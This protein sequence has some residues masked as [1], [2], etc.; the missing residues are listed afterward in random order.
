V[1]AT[2]ASIVAAAT[3]LIFAVIG[4]T[5]TERSGVINLSLE[6]SLMLAALAGFAAGFQTGEWWVGFVAAALVGGAVAG[7]VAWASIELRV[8]QVAVGFVLALLCIELS[9]FLGVSFVGQPGAAV[10]HWEIPL[11]ADIPWLGAVFFSHDVVV[12][13]GLALIVVSTWYMFRTGPGLVLR[14]IGERPE[15]AHARAV[16]VNRLRYRYALIG[17][18]LV[19]IGGAAFSL[20]VKLGWSFRHTA[21]FGWIALAI[22][23]FGGWHPLR[24][25]FGAYLFGALQVVALKLQPTFPGLSQILP[26]LPFPL[27]IFTLVL[28]NRSWFR[29]LA[30]RFP[31]WRA[32]LATD[33]PAALGH[34]FES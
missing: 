20:D 5:I 10:P 6:G 24:A 13:A 33:A 17:G 22:V 28:V 7:L 2:L 16:A 11:L 19:G 34:P 4:E 25:A 18:A 8:N 27:M 30:D 14:G 26:L 15:A 29:S 3:P 23:I 21:G 12:Y 32:V 31:S 1:E 9:S